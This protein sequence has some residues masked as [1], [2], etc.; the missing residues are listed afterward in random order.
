MLAIDMQ[1]AIYTTRAVTQDGVSNSPPQ[2]T[3]EVIGGSSYSRGN[4]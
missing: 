2:V 4:E 1:N 3:L